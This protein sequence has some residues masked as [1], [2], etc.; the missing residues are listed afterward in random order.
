MFT[1]KDFFY[2]YWPIGWNNKVTQKIDL[3]KRLE[4]MMK[5]KDWSGETFEKDDEIKIL[6]NHGLNSTRT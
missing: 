4:N 3:A 5:P 1:M 6:I 2:N